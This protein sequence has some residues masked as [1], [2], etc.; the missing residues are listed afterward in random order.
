MYREFEASF[1]FEETLTSQ[2]HRRS[3]RGHG[4]G[5]AHGPPHLAATWAL[6]NRGP[7]RRLPGRAGRQVAMLCPTTVLAEQHYQTSRRLAGFPVN[8][9]MLSRFVSRIKQKEVLDATAKGQI[10]ILIGTHRL[11]SKDV[12]IL[13]SA[14]SFWTKNS[15][16]ACATRNA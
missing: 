6:A 14:C 3:A 9:G 2:G 7:A 1:G 13:G 10:D 15:A 4:K 8:I 12:V 5:R 11:L 16:L